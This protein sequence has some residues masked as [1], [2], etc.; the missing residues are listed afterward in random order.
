MPCCSVWSTELEVT[1]IALSDP[2]SSVCSLSLVP[3]VSL[4]GKQHSRWEFRETERWCNTEW[5]EGHWLVKDIFS[6]WELVVIPKR[7]RGLLLAVQF[8]I[9]CWVGVA[10]QRPPHC[11]CCVLKG[12][13]CHMVWMHSVVLKTHWW[14][15]WWGLGLP[16]L[17]ARLLSLDGTDKGGC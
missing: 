13:T 4:R 9:A 2:V 10:L 6:L 12:S 8:R 15:G 7:T 11:F 1:V 14:R 5:V 16:G 17:Q 3:C